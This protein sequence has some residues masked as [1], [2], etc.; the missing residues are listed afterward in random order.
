[1]SDIDAALQAIVIVTEITSLQSMFKQLLV[2][3]TSH[4][5]THIDGRSQRK[6][7]TNT[8]LHDLYWEINKPEPASSQSYGQQMGQNL[9]WICSAVWSNFSDQTEAETGI[10]SILYMVQP[11]IF[12]V[13]WVNHTQTHHRKLPLR[14]TCPSQDMVPAQC[15]FLPLILWSRRILTY[16]RC[17][18]GYHF[19]GSMVFW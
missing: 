17:V 6:R 3:S 10:L 7:D 11:E 12:S 4:L 9:T 5:M 14:S 18:S 19:Q 13:G 15:V 8:F 1:M 16:P 2:L